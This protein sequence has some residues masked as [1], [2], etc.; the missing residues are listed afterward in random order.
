MERRTG[1]DFKQGRNVFA[2]GFQFLTC[3][4]C[5]CN[6]ITE[7]L[8]TDFF[9]ADEETLVV[10]L[11]MGGGIRSRAVARGGQDRGKH[12]GGGAFAVCAGNMDDGKFFFRTA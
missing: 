11:Q 6:F 12:S 7:I 4:F 5:Q 3:L 9:P 10:P 1:D 2:L 8:V